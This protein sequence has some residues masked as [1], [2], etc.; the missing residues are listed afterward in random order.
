MARPVKKK[1]I[2]SLPAIQE[3][4]PGNTPKDMPA[5]LMPLE[6]YETIRLT[7]YNGLNQ[8]ECS[9]QMNVARTTVQALYAAARKRMA[10]C[11]VEGRPLKIIGGEYEICHDNEPCCNSHRNNNHCPFRKEKFM[12]IAVTYSNGEIFQHFGKTNEFK[13][14][15]IEDNKVVKSEVI[16]TNGQGHGALAGILQ[17]ENIDIL[18]C[19]GIGGGAQNALAY[20]GIKLYGGVQGN[21]D[22][23]VEA[24]LAGKLSYD[25]AVRCD[26]HGHGEGHTCGDHGCH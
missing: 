19:G 8:Q 9:K 20:A 21:A 14:Y 23:A 18:I 3:F 17:Q 25:P 22:V 24:L 16:S 13:V 26:H 1:K 6:E 12:K 5:I 11:L 10:A 15:D 2:C 4:V 7:D